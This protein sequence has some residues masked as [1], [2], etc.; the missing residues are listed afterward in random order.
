MLHMYTL[1]HVIKAYM[2]QRDEENSIGIKKC[3]Y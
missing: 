2:S 1:M 3:N